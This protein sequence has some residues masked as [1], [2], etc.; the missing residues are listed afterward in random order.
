MNVAVDQGMV[1]VPVGVAVVNRIVAVVV[2][3]CMMDDTGHR[4]WNG[5]VGR[6]NGCGSGGVGRHL[7]HGAG[8]SWLCGLVAGHTSGVR[9]G[10]H[11]VGHVGG[12]RNDYM[13]VGAGHGS[14]RH[15]VCWNVTGKGSAGRSDDEDKLQRAEN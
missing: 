4:S 12:R 3:R 1:V 5:S 10:R 6:V 2:G 8:H 11:C 15:G 9:H 14:H 13:M 7:G